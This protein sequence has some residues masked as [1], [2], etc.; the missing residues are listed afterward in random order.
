MKPSADYTAVAKLSHWLTALLLVGSFSLGYYMVDLAMSPT[1]LKLYSY[2]KWIGVT[3]FALV[4]FRLLWRFTHKPPALPAGM[5]P[6]EKHAAEF[7]HWLLYVLLFLA[8]LSGWMMS[9]AKGFQTVYFGVLP[10]PD[11]VPKSEAL[12]NTL[13]ELHELFVFG[14]FGLAALHIAAAFKHHFINRDNVLKRML[15]RFK[16]SGDA[17]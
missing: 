1:K 13:E 4:V 6:W 5:K 10:I 2:H 15:P 7:T 12:G 3:V 14:L 8:P 11:L 9:S 17:S 16:Q